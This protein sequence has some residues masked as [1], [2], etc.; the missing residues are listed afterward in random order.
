MLGCGICLKIEFGELYWNVDKIFV[1]LIVLVGWLSSTFGSIIQL[2][3]CAC[4]TTRLH[5]LWTT[6]LYRALRG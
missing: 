6:L 5:F 1:D 2:Q 4:V 3:G